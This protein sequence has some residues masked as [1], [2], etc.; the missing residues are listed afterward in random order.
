MVKD[1]KAYLLPIPIL[2]A[3]FRG[4]RT[5]QSP[6]FSAIAPT[7]SNQEHVR[8]LRASFSADPGNGSR[9]E[10]PHDCAE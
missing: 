1:E 5:Y 4:T 6:S 10:S 2:D 8:R 3:F 9:G 7:A